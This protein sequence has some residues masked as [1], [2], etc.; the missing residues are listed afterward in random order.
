[1][2]QAKAEQREA[3]RKLIEDGQ[4]EIVTGGWVMSDEAN[5]HYYAMIDQLMLGKRSA[6]INSH[7][8][9][10]LRIAFG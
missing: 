1:M 10:Y 7:G 9:N 3:L 8:D 6:P 4:L 5:A 2:N